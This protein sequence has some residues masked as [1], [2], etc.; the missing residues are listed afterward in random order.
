M[1]IRRNIDEMSLEVWKMS[2]ARCPG[3]D[4]LAACASEASFLCRI[5]FI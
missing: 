5:Q 1:I 3:H 2:R 4:K